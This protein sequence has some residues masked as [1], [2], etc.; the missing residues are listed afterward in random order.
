MRCRCARYDFM[1][2][3]I[4]KELLEVRCLVFL[5]AAYIGRLESQDGTL[6]SILLSNIFMWVQLIILQ[7]QSN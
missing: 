7:L 3:D 6:I 1:Q 4:Y 2:L 5:T